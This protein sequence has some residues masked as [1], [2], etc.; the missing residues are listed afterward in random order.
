MIFAKPVFRGFGR[1]GIGSSIIAS[2]GSDPDLEKPASGTTTALSH[3][4]L[5]AISLSAPWL[6]AADSRNI[7]NFRIPARAG[8]NH[9]SHSCWFVCAVTTL[10]S[11]NP[12]PV[13]GCGKML[14]VNWS[15]APWRGILPGPERGRWPILHVL[16]RSRWSI[17]HIRA[18]SADHRSRSP[19]APAPIW[20]PWQG[21]TI[22]TSIAGAYKTNAR[23]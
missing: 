20:D 19:P 15:G 11:L 5:C 22:T 23:G 9:K 21:G 13:W 17:H 7:R 3:S 16:Q 4:L 8:G 18:W 6:R 14:V 2:A 10:P 12:R 1:R